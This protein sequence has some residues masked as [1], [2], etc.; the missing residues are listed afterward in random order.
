MTHLNYTDI[1]HQPSNM[2]ATAVTKISNKTV[3]VTGGSRGIGLEVG[4]GNL[5]CTSNPC[6]AYGSCLPAPEVAEQALYNTFIS[7]AWR[8]W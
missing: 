2:T 6:D 5:Q 1:G 4:P 3:V 8:S 7:L